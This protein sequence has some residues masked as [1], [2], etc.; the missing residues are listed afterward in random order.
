MKPV[1]AKF[2]PRILAPE[3]KEQRLSISLELC[4]RV[5]SDP[6]FFQNLITGEES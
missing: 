2:V 5:T 1:S 6:N 4:D 3:Q